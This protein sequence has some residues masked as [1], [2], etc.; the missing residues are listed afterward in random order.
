VSLCVVCGI[1][2]VGDVV[3]CPHHLHVEDAGWARGNRVLC[4]FFHRGK[5]IERPTRAERDEDD[6]VWAVEGTA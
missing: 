2:R 6:I 3:F 4:D 1:P 5:P